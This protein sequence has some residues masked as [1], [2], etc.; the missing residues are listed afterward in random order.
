VTGPAE[1]C[2][3]ASETPTG[4]LGVDVAQAAKYPCAADFSASI[5]A[6][7]ATFDAEI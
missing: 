1:H 6:L 4:S 2:A 5:F 3:A 7:S